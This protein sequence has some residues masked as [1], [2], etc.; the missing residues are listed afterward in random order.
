[1][2][3]TSLIEIEKGFWQVAGNADGPDYY[4]KYFADDGVMVLPFEHGILS[5]S[6]V[7]S[8]LE[9]AAK[10]TRFDFAN[11][12]SHKISSDCTLI[13]YSTQASHGQDEYRANITSIYK[14]E[15]GQPVMIFHQQTPI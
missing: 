5:K 14:T 3:E 10:W 12:S 13:T 4:Q 11:I 7:I 6:A 2:D 1:M 9:N 8:S 15:N